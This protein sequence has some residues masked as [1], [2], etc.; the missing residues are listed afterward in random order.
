MTEKDFI[1]KVR[2]GLEPYAELIHK[3]PDSARALI[4]PCDII[5]SIKGQCHA[6]ECKHRKFRRDR[7]KRIKEDD[8]I[9]TQGMMRP[10]QV[11]NLRKLHNAGG[12]GV[13]CALLSNEYY[14]LQRRG[15]AWEISRF[16]Q[17]EVWKIADIAG[18]LREI[19]MYWEQGG[20]VL[21]WLMKDR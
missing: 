11:E 8:V 5:A 20:W 18:H 2:K 16:L 9:I 10:H 13:V 19:E 1:E 14:S 12:R 17:Q 15:F 21:P 3:P 6:I 7:E 4:K